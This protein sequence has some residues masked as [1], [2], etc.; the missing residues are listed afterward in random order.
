[1]CY[2]EAGARG[3][4]PRRRY[5]DTINDEKEVNNSQVFIWSAFYAREGKMKRYACFVLVLAAFL[6][7]ASSVSFGV[8]RRVVLE[9]FTNTS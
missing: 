8:Q 9:Y 3:L 7:I 5:G 1:M 4:A 2:V 6:L